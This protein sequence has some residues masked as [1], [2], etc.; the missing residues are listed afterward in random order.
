[1]DPAFI[2]DRLLKCSKP[3]LQ[4]AREHS[5][6]FISERCLFLCMSPSSGSFISSAPT[7]VTFPELHHVLLKQSLTGLE[8]AKYTRLL[9]RMLQGSFCLCLPISGGDRHTP[10]HLFWLLFCFVFVPGSNVW[11]HAHEALTLLS[12]SVPL[13]S[14]WAFYYFSLPSFSVVLNTWL[15]YFCLGQRWANLISKRQQVF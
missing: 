6:Y 2:H 1:M 3:Q 14:V 7:S 5:W 13:F 15:H 9:S 10:P 11:L 4:H 8:L 12:D